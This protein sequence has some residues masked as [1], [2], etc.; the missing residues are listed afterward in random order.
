MEALGLERGTASFHPT[1]GWSL[2]VKDISENSKA[3]S[4]MMSDISNGMSPMEALT[5]NMATMHP[6]AV[7]NMGA[8]IWNTTFADLYKSVKAL[9]QAQG[10]TDRDVRA[11]VAQSMADSGYPSSLA[12]KEI[13]ENIKYKSTDPMAQLMVRNAMLK[14]HMDRGDVAGATAIQQG[15]KLRDAGIAPMTQPPAG[16]SLAENA[17]RLKEGMPQIVQTPQGPMVFAGHGT[18]PG[19]QLTGPNGPIRAPMTDAESK[20]LSEPRAAFAQLNQLIDLARPMVNE[21]GQYS[22]RMSDLLLGARNFST[23]QTIGEWLSGAKDTAHGGPF[24]PSEAAFAQKLAAMVSTQNLGRMTEND[25][26][27]KIRAWGGGTSGHNIISQLESTRD[28]DVAKH[29]VMVDTIT[30]QG[31]ETGPKL[32]LTSELNKAYNAVPQPRYGYG[33]VFSPVTKKYYYKANESQ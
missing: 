5:N 24:T 16:L 13:Q 6:N 7:K 15:V 26:K 17:K 23:V 28:A 8:S 32:P 27:A 12:P 3:Y 20:Q 30:T 9:P 1:Q 4:S 11:N 33:I 2:T 10:L 14:L 22:T 29:N 21:R 19:T 25:I 18:Q 31:K